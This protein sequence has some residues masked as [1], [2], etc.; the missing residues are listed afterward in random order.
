MRQLQQLNPEMVVTLG[1]Q[2]GE[3]LGELAHLIMPY[4]HAALKHGDKGEVLRK[5]SMLREVLSTQGTDCGCDRGLLGEEI[6]CPIFK[7]NV[8]GNWSTA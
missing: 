5:A 8:R 2:A 1:K 6:R 4:P 3:A 7:A